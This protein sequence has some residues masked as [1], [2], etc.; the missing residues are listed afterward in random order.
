MTLTCEAG[1][2]AFCIVKWHE[3]MEMEAKGFG[4]KWICLCDQLEKGWTCGG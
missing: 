4:L 3:P 2:D 1:L